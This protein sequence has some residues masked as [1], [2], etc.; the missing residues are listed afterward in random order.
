MGPTSSDRPQMPDWDRTYCDPEHHALGVN[1]P[2]GSKGSVEYLR[3]SGVPDAIDAA[4][5]GLCEQRPTDARRWLAE[6]FLQSCPAAA[7][8]VMLMTPPGHV[9]SRNGKAE[10]LRCAQHV[11]YVDMRQMEESE[12]Q[13]HLRWA[14][15]RGLWKETIQS[16]QQEQQ[17]EEKEVKE[18]EGRDRRMIEKMAGKGETIQ[19]I[20]VGQQREHS[21]LCK[22]EDDAWNTILRGSGKREITFRNILKVQH[23]E[24]G[25]LRKEE[26]DAFAD[27]ERA[28]GKRVGWTQAAHQVEDAEAQPEWAEGPF[29]DFIRGLVPAVDTERL[30]KDA[31]VEAPLKVAPGARVVA[32]IGATGHGKS[33]LCCALVGERPGDRAA[34]T[35]FRIAA[36]AAHV[37][38]T[39]Q[40]LTGRHFDNDERKCELFLVDTPGLHDERGVD[41]DAEN[42]QEMIRVF[43]RLPVG[44]HAFLLV[45]NADA[46]RFDDA[47][48]STVRYFEEQ[49]GRDFWHNVV[50]VVQRWESHTIARMKRE[51]NGITEEQRREQYLSQLEEHFPSAQAA[52]IPFCFVDTH[53]HIYESLLKPEE[54]QERFKQWAELYARI[55]RHKPHVTNNM[56]MQVP[57]ESSRKATEL[58]GAAELQL[59]KLRDAVDPD[60]PS[61]SL[62]AAISAD[63]T[64]QD[65]VRRI[66]ELTP[67][68]FAQEQVVRFR[69]LVADRIADLTR[70]HL[71]RRDRA[72]RRFGEALQKRYEAA[73]VVPKAGEELG[74]NPKADYLAEFDARWGGQEGVDAARAAFEGALDQHWGTVKTEWCGEVSYADEDGDVMLFRPAPGADALQYCVNGSERPPFR[75]LIYNKSLGI[76]GITMPDVGKGFRLPKSEARRVLGGLRVLAAKVGIECNIEVEEDVPEEEGLP[77]EQADALIEKRKEQEEDA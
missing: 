14:Q 53:A 19:S 74:E 2:G 45:V 32:V 73:V 9:L 39:V 49:F 65:C 30:E 5:K 21:A 69:Q 47:L 57:M 17:R 54:Q 43:K 27:I 63:P 36:T 18:G 40:V 61:E 46:V 55:N 64:I 41:K 3:A 68:L 25:I 23:E 60:Q 6:H 59:R 33:S 70:V 38:E 42:I 1:M 34:Q 31:A 52:N 71:A 12:F 44:V 48:M 13:G 67:P 29:A 62:T 8:S 72:A 50:F 76:P 75:R 35:T 28:A 58:Y 77:T 7:A 56:L 66:R 15:Q 16:I 4:M 37:T 26:V 10:I 11:H 51:A 20:T 24:Y 22:A